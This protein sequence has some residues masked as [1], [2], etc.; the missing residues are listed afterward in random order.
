MRATRKIK[1]LTK[2]RMIPGRSEMTPEKIR[3]QKEALISAMRQLE[4]EYRE[5]CAE[6]RGAN[7]LAQSEAVPAEGHGLIETKLDIDDEDSS[8]GKK[9]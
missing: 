5:I 7:L 2:A 6:Y 4:A 3:I 9:A 8:A 1:K